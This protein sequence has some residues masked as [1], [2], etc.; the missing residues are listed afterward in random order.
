[1]TY[2]TGPAHAEKE[3]VRLREIETELQNHII[4]LSDNPSYL[5]SSMRSTCANRLRYE[6][7]PAIKECLDMIKQYS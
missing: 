2:I 3:L 1:M 4:E 5:S 6:I 7:R